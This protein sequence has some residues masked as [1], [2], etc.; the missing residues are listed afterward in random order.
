MSTH[1]NGARICA[2]QKAAKLW[3]AGLYIRLSKEDELAEES[4][5]ISSQ[6]EILREHLKQ[7]PDI[8]EYDCYI[9]DGWSG[10]NFHRNA[11]QEP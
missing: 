1:K 10:T 6:R 5:S 2:P 7:H 4:N 9:D 3:H 8:V 11:R